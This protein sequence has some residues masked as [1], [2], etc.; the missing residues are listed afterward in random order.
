MCVFKLSA[1]AKFMSLQTAGFFSVKKRHLCDTPLP[2]NL[3]DADSSSDLP[4]GER[5]LFLGEIL[6]FHDNDPW[7][8]SRYSLPQNSAL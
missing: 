6:A 2:V 4:K 8:C 1:T 5:N 3:P 7:R